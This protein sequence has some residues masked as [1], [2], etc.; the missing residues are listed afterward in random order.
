MELAAMSSASVDDMARIHQWVHVPVVLNYVGSVF[1]VRQY[2]GTGRMGLG[3]TLIALRCIGAVASLAS[4]GGLYFVDIEALRVVSLP[5]GQS[6]VLPV[7]QLSSLHVLDTI[8]LVGLLLFVIDAAWSV[9]KR[10]RR[11]F[12]Y[13]GV[14]LA[15]AIAF[16]NIAILVHVPMIHLHLG[17]LPYMVGWSFLPTILVMAYSMS[18]DLLQTARLA[19]DLEEREA[20]LRDSE[21]RLSL[22]ADAGGVALWSWDEQGKALWCNERARREFAVR[23]VADIDRLFRNMHADDREHLRDVTRATAVGGYYELDVR[24]ETPAD[25]RWLAVRGCIDDG[26]PPGGPVIVRGAAIDITS[27]RHLEQELRTMR[28]EIAHLSRVTMLGE[29]SGA[30]AHELNQPLA[31]ILSNAQAAQR[32]M[33]AGGDAQAEVEEILADIVTEDRRASEVIYRL[34]SLLR[35]GELAL[36]EVGLNEAVQDVLKLL[37]SDLINRKVELDIELAEEDIKVRAARVQLQQV[38]VN[39]VVNACD[40]LAQLGPSERRVTVKVAPCGDTSALVSVADN[41]P[42]ISQ[43]LAN[44]IFEPFVTTKEQGMGLGLAVCRTIVL[45][46]G[47]QL[48]VDDSSDSGARFCFTLLRA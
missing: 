44:R 20:S 21:Q 47:G 9:R 30:I 42:G 28:D 33:A 5:F 4:P 38:L 22:A 15:S 23:D 35:K 13:R 11:E 17:D 40:A 39:L 26:E 45:A 16:Y 43:Q 8:T 19:R 46:H 27:R 14:W 3:Y 24:I 6:I 12:W 1:F 48:W 31:A 7:G 25:L 41:G 37:R 34:R 10:A 18:T 36:E 29:L 2:F 32:F